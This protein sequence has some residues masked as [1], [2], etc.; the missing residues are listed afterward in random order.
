MSPFE[1][2]DP[3]ETKRSTHLNLKIGTLKKAYDFMKK[4]GNDNLSDFVTDALEYFVYEQKRELKR[5]DKK[6]E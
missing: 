6:H 2:K 1:T 3:M 4:I 5:K